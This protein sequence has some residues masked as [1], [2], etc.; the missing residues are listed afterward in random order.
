MGRNSIDMSLVPDLGWGHLKNR[1][2][3]QLQERLSPLPETL[4]RAE[5]AFWFSHKI[6]STEEDI[7]R[8][9]SF[10]RA[11]LAEYVSMEDT[12]D[13]DL[14]KAEISDEPVRIRDFEDPVLH[15]IRELRNLELHLRTSELSSDEIPAI[16]GDIEFD[17]QIWF[18]NDLEIEHVLNN[19]YNA[20][21][22]DDD[23]LRKLIDWF[24]PAQRLM[25]IG[26][27]IRRA[28]ITYARHIVNEYD[29]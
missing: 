28:V 15:I 21:Y 1:L 23:D 10:L 3:P 13:R 2:D 16:S 14:D 22:Y 20:R 19:L 17:K 9:E 12:L 18:V 11:S 25:G 6:N 5:G 29:P 8:R 4:D 7:K 24:N 27:L 26:E